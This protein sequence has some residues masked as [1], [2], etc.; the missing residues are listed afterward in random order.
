MIAGTQKSPPTL[1]QGGYLRPHSGEY[2]YHYF[3]ITCAV[4]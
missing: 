1:G 2:L 4:R 3:T